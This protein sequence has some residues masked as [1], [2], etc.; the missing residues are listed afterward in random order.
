MRSTYHLCY[1]WAIPNGLGRL[2]LWQLLLCLRPSGAEHALWDL[3]RRG[4]RR[5]LH[6]C[7]ARAATVYPGLYLTA[8]PLAKLTNSHLLGIATCGW[9]LESCSKVVGAEMPALVGAREDSERVEAVVEAPARVEAVVEYSRGQAGRTWLEHT[10]LS[11]RP[12]ST[13]GAA[14]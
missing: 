4:S 7:A 2:V 6:G 14:D 8:Q 9:S 11:H 1:S 10:H 13:A 3:R 12:H 5:P